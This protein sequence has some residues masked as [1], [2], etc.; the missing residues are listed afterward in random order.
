MRWPR[1]RRRPA[2]R[3][4]PVTVEV[5]GEQITAIVRSEQPMSDES[6]A[7]FAEIVAAAKRRYE[8]EHPETLDLHDEN[9]VSRCCCRPDSRVGDCYPCS[10]GEHQGCP[11]RAR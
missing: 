6:R 10:A 9:G 2:E 5:D 4:R 3:C 11:E 7:Y 8:A 1:L